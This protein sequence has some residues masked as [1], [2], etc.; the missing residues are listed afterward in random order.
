M[1]FEEKIQYIIDNDGSEGGEYFY[2]L[3]RFIQCLGLSKKEKAVLEALEPVVDYWYKMTKEDIE[4][5]QSSELYIFDTLPD[6]CIVYLPDCK[7]LLIKVKD[8]LY[9]QDGNL[10]PVHK[11]AEFLIHTTIYKKETSRI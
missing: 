10:I 7:N 9:N 2:G 11:D 5:Q 4:E 1:T 8:K 6:N 3:Q